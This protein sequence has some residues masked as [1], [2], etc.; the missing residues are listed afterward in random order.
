VP[1][2]DLTSFFKK[3]WLLT[4]RKN[5]LLMNGNLLTMSYLMQFG[6]SFAKKM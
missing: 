2:C 3:K 4:A 1:F 6:L 5:Q